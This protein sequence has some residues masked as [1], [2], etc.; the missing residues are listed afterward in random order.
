MP[1]TTEDVEVIEGFYQKAEKELQKKLSVLRQLMEDSRELSISNMAPYVHG[2]FEAFEHVKPGQTWKSSES[3]VPQY[4]DV[5]GYDYATCPFIE[6]QTGEVHI[7]LKALWYRSGTLSA[8]TKSS[9]EFIDEC[10]LVDNNP[11]KNSN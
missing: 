6:E 1:L 10:E 7:R 9:W 8:V 3:S 2:Y 4:Y 5:I 11:L